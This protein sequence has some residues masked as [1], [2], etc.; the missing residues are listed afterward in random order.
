MDT[1]SNYYFLVVVLGYLLSVPLCEGCSIPGPPHQENLQ[2][3]DVKQVCRGELWEDLDEHLLLAS[4]GEVG[5]S[6]GEIGS[7]L[8]R[9]C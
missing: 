2:Q 6:N 9:S 7:V 3:E 4:Q 5:D 8:S 1:P